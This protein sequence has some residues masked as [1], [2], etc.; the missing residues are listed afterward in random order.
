MEYPESVY[1]SSLND[2]AA[3]FRSTHYNIDPPEDRLKY[4]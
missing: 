3:K 2:F 4:Y 1:K